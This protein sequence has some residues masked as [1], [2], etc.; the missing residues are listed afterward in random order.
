MSKTTNSILR[1]FI[2]VPMMA[3]T[4]SMSAFTASINTVLDSKAQVTE[5]TQELSAEEAALQLEREETAAKIDA[6]YKKYNLPLAGYGMK[7]VLA[8]EK[9]D[10][11][12]LLLAAM[13]MRETTGGKFACH[14]NPFG[15]GSCKIKFESFDHAIDVVAMN[16]GGHNPRTASYYKGKTVTGI[17]KTYNSVI[18]TYATEVVSIM[19][20]I[21]STVI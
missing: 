20:K 10:I 14:N 16:L 11:E 12:P 3:T 1:S 18:P 2:I 13:A 5:Q 21:D 9:Y 8:G 17:L 7:M 6:Y 15:W 19:K 4:I